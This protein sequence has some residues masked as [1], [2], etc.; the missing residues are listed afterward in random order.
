MQICKDG[1]YCCNNEPTC[2]DEGKGVFLNEQGFIV[3][4]A[5]STTATPTETR[6]AQGGSPT[7]AT[8]A[9]SVAQASAPTAS[10]VETGNGLPSGVKVAIGVVVPVTVLLITALAL[11]IW[12][13]RKHNRGLQAS[14]QK[15]E[16]SLP[17]DSWM[18][19]ETKAEMPGDA[20]RSELP[21][22]APIHELS[23]ATSD[24]RD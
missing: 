23:T 22:F 16:H 19:N 5:G 3:S 18:Y 8:S 15:P 11:I 20:V 1:S 17:Q 9:T 21:A 10:A 6:G 4:T 24:K 12:R 2:C 7:S 13:L 14:L